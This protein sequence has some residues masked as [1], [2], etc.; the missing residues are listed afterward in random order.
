M[1]SGLTRSHIL[2]FDKHFTSDCHLGWLH[3]NKV[4]LSTSTAVKYSVIV[5]FS[6]YSKYTV[7]LLYS[8][9]EYAYAFDKYGASTITS[10]GVPYDYRSVMHYGPFAFSRNGQRTIEPKVSQMLYLFLV[11]ICGICGRICGFTT[12]GIRFK[13]TQNNKIINS[14]APA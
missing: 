2:A 8:S 13:K 6:E 9:A 3:K 12:K 10:F 14:Q 7:Q 11:S 5:W 1:T 4:K